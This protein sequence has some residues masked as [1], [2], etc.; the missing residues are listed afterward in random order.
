MKPVYKRLAEVLQRRGITW[1]GMINAMVPALLGELEKGE[2]TIAD[3][4]LG[5]IELKERND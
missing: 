2:G 4:N 1:N 5:T 3:L